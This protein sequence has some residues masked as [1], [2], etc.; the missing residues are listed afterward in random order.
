M[1]RRRV[2]ELAVV[3]GNPEL[4]DQAEGSEQF[5]LVE[6]YFYKSLFVK[7]IEA[8][9][10]KPNQ[11]CEKNGA[12]DDDGDQDREQRFQEKRHAKSRREK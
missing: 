9:G 4:F 5:R 1:R 8:P 6:N 7:E 3:T 12:R 2:I 11:V 10:T